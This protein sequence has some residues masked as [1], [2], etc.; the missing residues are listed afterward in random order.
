MGGSMDRRTLSQLNP[1][2]SGCIYA[3]NTTHKA[4]RRRL[5]DMGMVPYTD[6]KVKRIAPMGDPIEISMRG[7]SLSIRREDAEKIVIMHDDERE[8]LLAEWKEYSK[9][10][11]AQGREMLE[12]IMHEDKS[13]EHEH[14]RA[15]K[16]T[17]QFL[18]FKRPCETGSGKQACVS[19][20]SDDDR[21]V[22]LAL[23]GNPNCGK[24]T[25]FNAMTGSR[26]TVGNWP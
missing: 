5:I 25:L 20:V 4:L 24:T 14:E 21:P 19:E 18:K 12:A 23:V 3:I 6:I 8:S 22:K 7:F 13:D 11:E 2:E 26:A 9:K 1:G 16:L 10:R 15:A 17:K